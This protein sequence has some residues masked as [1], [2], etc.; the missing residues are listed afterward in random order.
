MLTAWSLTVLMAIDKIQAVIGVRIA[1]IKEASYRYG[2]YQDWRQIMAFQVA[3]S[4]YFKIDPANLKL[5]FIP[6]E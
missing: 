4:R 3:H 1:E 5:N 6:Y 2:T